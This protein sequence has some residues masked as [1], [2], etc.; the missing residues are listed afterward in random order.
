MTRTTLTGPPFDEGALS[1][2]RGS[3][4]GCVADPRALCHVSPREEETDPVPPTPTL[5]GARIGEATGLMG[6]RVD[7]DDG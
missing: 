6:N 3:A 5:R 1:R 7:R 2:E 4:P